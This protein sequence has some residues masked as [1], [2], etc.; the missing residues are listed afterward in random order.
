MV[1]VQLA[2]QAD[3]GE[4]RTQARDLLHRNISPEL[5]TWCGPDADSIL[6]GVELSAV[7]GRAPASATP[8]RVPREFLA[9]VERVIAH[10]DT[11]RFALLYR[12][13]W[14]LSRE[15]PRLLALLTDADVQRARVM[16]QAVKRDAH[17]MK[18][19]VRFREVRVEELA[20]YVAWFEPEHYIV[21][22]VA[23][24][25]V[26]RFTGMRFSILT[27]YRSAHWD[28]AALSYGPG[29]T[30]QDA[31]SADSVENVWRTYYANIFNPA[32]LNVRAMQAEMPQKF[33]KN[34]PEAELI[35]KLIAEA[36]AQM[37]GMIERAPTTPRKRIAVKSS[38]DTSVTNTASVNRRLSLA[39][40]QASA[41]DCRRCPLWQPATQTVFGEGPETASTVFIGE[42]PGDREDLSGK[43]F[44]GPAGQLFD[45]ALREVGVDR[46]GVYI[47]N[48][49]KHFKF[50]PRGKMRLHMRANAMEQ[51]ACRQWLDAELAVLKPRRIVCLGA[52][53]A[54]AIFG[55][56]FRLMAERGHWRQLE[57]GVAALAT[58][59]PA[60]LLRLPAEDREDGYRAF[61][62]DL[63]LL[64]LEQHLSPT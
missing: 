52:M 55:S 10:R 36:P 59:H 48:T 40:L 2:T 45:R 1:R 29:L 8:K 25:F 39:E 9:L 32:R 47:T 31:P 38:G 35:A 50:E 49:V 19:F 18:A 20:G 34:L 14:R 60:Y 23:P 16:A 63:S 57:D 62:R 26:R 33:W 6:A 58:V 11:Q 56:S 44:V 17:K 43:P 64:T 28:L 46:A 51:M 4:W 22:L 41:R 30:R 15:E 42:Q 7:A 21:D 13:L 61:V 27:P 24:F 37:Q 12:I 3:V 53:A 54:Q 5:V